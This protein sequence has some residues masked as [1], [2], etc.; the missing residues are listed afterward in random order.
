M[1][2]PEELEIWSP[3]RLPARAD[4]PTLVIYG[5]QAGNGL[6]EMGRAGEAL[7]Y[8][9]AAL[10]IAAMVKD[11]GFPYIAYGCKARALALLGRPEE[12]R[13]LMEQT[14]KQTGQLHLPLEQ[15]QALIVLGQVAAAVGDPRAATQY[16]EEA[17]RLSRV[18]SLHR[19]EH[20]RSRKG[21]S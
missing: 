11:I 16:F 20:V 12:A 17:G 5:S 14:L 21:L 13:K 9:N 2:I 1:A 19:V 3:P 8:C 7:D 4:L 15:S 18:H 6:V 10:H